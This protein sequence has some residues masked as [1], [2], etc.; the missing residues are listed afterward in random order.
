MGGGGGR[1]H[2]WV[3][4]V[5]RRAFPFSP[6]SPLATCF[7]SIQGRSSLFPLPYLKGFQDRHLGRT[8]GQPKNA[9]RRRCPRCLSF[10]GAR[11]KSSFRADTTTR[12]LPFVRPFVVSFFSSLPILL[13]YHYQLAEDNG[14]RKENEKE[15]NMKH[16][17][18]FPNRKFLPIIGGPL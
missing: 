10:C 18:N 17:R 1:G 4:E 8:M 14:K 2:F 9:C 11:A 15:E 5:P 3:S 7:F 12:R 13:Y 6:T 16:Q